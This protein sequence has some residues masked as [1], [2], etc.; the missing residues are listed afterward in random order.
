M[1]YD[2]KVPDLI[3]PLAWDLETIGNPDL[4]DSLPEPTPKANLK[5]KAKIEAD[6]AEKKAKQISKMALNGNT[7]LIVACGLAGITKEGEEWSDALMYD[8]TTG[9]RPYVEALW[10]IFADHKAFITF[11]G[12]SF[13]VP[14]LLRRSLVL[15]IIP[16]LT[17]STRKYDRPPA[18][19]HY[20]LHQ[21]FGHHG[22]ME[23]QGFD[24]I[25]KYVLGEGK[26]EGIDGSMVGVF[27][28]AQKYDEIKAYAIDDALKTIQ[29][30]IRAK[31]IYFPSPR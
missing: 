12:I 15:G 31:G 30:W 21:I 29:L 22:G 14:I 25:C 4:I 17:I 27:W 19:N 5:D 18:G 1:S 6:I 11:N 28:G 8:P 2:L 23:T 26:P 9:E 3:S 13:D 7:A 20:D 16:P 10:D 24:Q